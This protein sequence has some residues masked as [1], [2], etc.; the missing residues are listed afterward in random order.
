MMTV[1]HL[2]PQCLP[3]TITAIPPSP[4]WVYL[5]GNLNIN[6]GLSSANATTTHRPGCLSPVDRLRFTPLRRLLVLRVSV[7]LPWLLLYAEACCTIESRR[8]SPPI[9]KSDVNLNHM[10][11]NN[12]GKFK[13]GVRALADSTN[14][15]NHS[16]QSIRTSIRSGTDR[17]VASLAARSKCL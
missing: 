16:I 12:S 8:E 13:Q 14:K 7:V 4:V 9:M 11:F 10:L 3:K 17:S 5:R 6:E 15:L 1:W 2:H